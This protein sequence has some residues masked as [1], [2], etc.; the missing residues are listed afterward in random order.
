MEDPKYSNGL[1]ELREDDKELDGF[2]LVRKELKNLRQ[3]FFIEVDEGEYTPNDDLLDAI[4]EM[5]FARVDKTMQALSSSRNSFS[6]LG[7]QRPKVEKEVVNEETGEVE[8]VKEIDK[9]VDPYIIP[10]AIPNQLVQEYKRLFKAANYNKEDLKSL[11]TATK[12]AADIAL[13]IVGNFVAGSMISTIEVEKVITGDPAFYKWKYFLDKNK[14][15]VQQKVTIDGITLGVDIL[16]EKDTDKIKRLG[17]VLS[18]GSEL[19]LDYTEDILKR[20]PELR[21]RKY[22]NANISDI[23]AKSVYID[24]LKLRFGKQLLADYVRKNR[25]D[26]K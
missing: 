15:R 22:T 5:L 20:F 26:Q 18:P 13:S 14:K 3:K 24:D 1:S 8:T 23:S 10:R 19:R 17:S 21:G 9:S 4:N 6:I 16:D 11:Y 7:R 2:E 25:P 12:G